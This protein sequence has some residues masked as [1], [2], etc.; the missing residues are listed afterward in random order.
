MWI[1]QAAVWLFLV[2][3][4]GYNPVGVAGLRGCGVAGLRGCGVAGVGS[5]ESDVTILR[6][7]LY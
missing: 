6:S 7:I 2:T 5:I 1:I 3:V 4:N